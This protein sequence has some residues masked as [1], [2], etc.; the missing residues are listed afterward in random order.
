MILSTNLGGSLVV[1]IFTKLSEIPNC[2]N[3]LPNFSAVRGVFSLGLT[4]IDVPAAIAGAILPTT[5]C[6]GR[7]KGVIAKTRSNGSLITF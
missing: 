5:W 2:F 4:I 7:L 6:K 3:K 1:I